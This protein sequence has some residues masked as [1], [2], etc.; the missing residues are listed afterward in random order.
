MSF[1]TYDG[2]SIQPFNPGAGATVSLDTSKYSFFQW[3]PGEAETIN[4]TTGGR[5]GQVIRVQILTS[6]VSSFNLTF[7]TNFLA[8]GVL[9][10]GTTTAKT[11][12]LTFVS[13]GTKFVEQSRTAAM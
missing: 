8:T 5:A 2:I 6:G 13:D 1:A 9:A 3:T 12:Q 11:F 10:T 4:A 7:S